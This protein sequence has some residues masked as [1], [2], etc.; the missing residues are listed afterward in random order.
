M[1]RMSLNS[2]TLLRVLCDNLDHSVVFF[3]KS[4]VVQC[5]LFSYEKYVSVY[6]IWWVHLWVTI[7]P[8]VENPYNC[9]VV[10]Y[11]CSLL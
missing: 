4:C 5:N 1:L 9:F 11:A 6:I 7:S 2:D 3:C 8:L 10:D